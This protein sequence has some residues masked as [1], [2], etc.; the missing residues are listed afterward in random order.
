[1]HTEFKRGVSV[2]KVSTDHTNGRR[3][4]VLDCNVNTGQSK[5][6]WHKQHIVRW[7]SWCSLSLHSSEP[8]GLSR[9]RKSDNIE[10]F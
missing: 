1:M 3:G 5:V 4:I 10:S 6:Y 8:L 7:C 2:V 9:V